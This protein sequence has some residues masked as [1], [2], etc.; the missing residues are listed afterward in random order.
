VTGSTLTFE[1]DY[2]LPREIVWDALIDPELVS[3][4]L[5]DAEIEPVLGGKFELTWLHP[6][7]LPPIAGRIVELDEPGSLRI[8]TANG[9]GIAF[10]LGDLEGGTRGR[11]TRLRIVV[12]TEVEEAFAARMK[13]YWLTDLD[14]LHDLLRGHPVDWAHWERDQSETWIAHLRDAE[15][16]SA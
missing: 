11:S 5:A 2:D 3:G 6:D 10:A 15:R 8:V 13:A 9:G 7:P 16:G 4:W 12:K 14:Q 1:R